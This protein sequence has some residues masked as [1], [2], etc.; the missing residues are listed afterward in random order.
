MKFGVFDHMD[1]GTVPLAEQYENRL[2]LLEAYERL[3]FY[4]YHIAEHHTTPLGM[5]SSPSVFLAAAAQRTHRLR[6]G[7]LVY[8]LPM[9]HPL[10]LAEEVCMLDH[11]SNGRLEV[12]VGRGVSPFELEH[13]GIDP[14]RSRDEYFEAFAVIIKALTSRTLDHEGKFYKFRDVPIEIE[15]LQR[16]HP[17]LW[18]GVSVPSAVPWAAQ[19]RINVVANGPVAMVRGVAD[20]YRAAWRAAGRPAAE[21]PLIAM[22]R[23]V[24]IAERAE[25]ALESARRAYARW[26]ASFI[27][28]W[29]RHGAKPFSATYPDNFDDAARMGFGVAGTPAQVRDVLAAQ[30]AE[31]G[32][33]Y[34]LCRAAFGDMSFDESLRSV[35]L[36]ARE[37]MP[38]LVA[39]RQAAE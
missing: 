26:Y 8:P 7:A 19:N 27:L 39:A 12:G 6:F 37:V 25:E 36:F 38:A 33:N 20:D 16:P 3:G 2:K 9:Y 34:F 10:R 1:R 17:P 28:L 5:A 14:A 30:V 18:Y 32:V 4:G 35:E 22:T 13:Y 29:N 11:L 23:H 31:A 15:P 21:L 24:V